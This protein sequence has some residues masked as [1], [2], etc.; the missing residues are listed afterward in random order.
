M[1]QG[2][3]DLAD[4]KSLV[5]ANLSEPYSS[6]TYHYFLHHFPYLCWLAVEEKSPGQKE[7]LRGVIM[8][9]IGDHKGSRRGYIGMLAVD[10]E[11][12]GRGVGTSLAQRLVNA[13]ITAAVDEIVLET[14][15]TN[16]QALALYGKLGFSRDKLLTSYYSDGSDAFR[17]KLWLS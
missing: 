16:K 6:F 13:M 17:L 9:R 14:Q 1:Y 10:R 5:E 12:Q 2:M 7:M 4:I 3:D 8:G 15:T 11:A